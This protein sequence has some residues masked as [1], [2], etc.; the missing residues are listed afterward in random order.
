MKSLTV[1][2][3]LAI[4][5]GSSLILLVFVA[6]PLKRLAGIPTLSQMI[7]PIHGILFLLFVVKTLSFA[8]ERNWQFRVITWKVL[9]ACLIP[10]G[11]FYIDH[12]ILKKINE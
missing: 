1:L 7:G 11:T 9:I 2:R 3:I 10:F 6:V 4:L 8:V 5:E 12:K